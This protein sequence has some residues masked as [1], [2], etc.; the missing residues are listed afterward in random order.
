MSTTSKQ[1]R[2]ALLKIE[3]DHGLKVFE[4]N[5]GAWLEGSASAMEDRLGPARAAEECYKLADR[6]ANKTAKIDV[7]AP[8][9]RYL[10]IL[11]GTSRK[12]GSIKFENIASQRHRWIR[13]ACHGL[14]YGFWIGWI[15]AGLFL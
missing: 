7:L 14:F 12:K 3:A 8:Q 10:P 9:E 15:C 11:K 1:I 13:A 4:E 6:W 2:A 5:S